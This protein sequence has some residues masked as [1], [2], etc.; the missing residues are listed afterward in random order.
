[1]HDVVCSDICIGVIRI[2]VSL[3]LK[4]EGQVHEVIT[5]LIGRRLQALLIPQH[6]EEA[7]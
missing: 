3:H 4:F 1:M 2:N 5:G 7:F 6:Q